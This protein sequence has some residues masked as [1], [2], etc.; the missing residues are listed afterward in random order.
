MMSETIMTE[1]FVIFVVV[2]I[3]FIFAAFDHR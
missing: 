2:V 1:V 3:V